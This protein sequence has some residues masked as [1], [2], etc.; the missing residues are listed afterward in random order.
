MSGG[1]KKI[2]KAPDV[3]RNV[4]QANDQFDTATSQAGQL[5]NTAQGYNQSAQDFN[6]RIV[7]QTTPAMD[8][9]NSN[10]TQNLQSYGQNFIPLQQQQ[11]ADAQRMSS[12]AYQAQ[13]RASAMADAG[14]ANAA[15]RKNSQRAL[16]SA[17]VDPYSVQG[18]ALD[19]QAGVVGAATQA[20]AG[21]RA[22]EAAQIQ[23]QQAV[24]NANNLGMQ[25]GQAG[26]ASGATGAQIGQSLVAGT[27]ATNAGAVNNSLAPAT[28]MG[29]AQNANNSA[30]NILSQNYQDQLA[31]TQAQAGGS[32]DMMGN[33]GALGGAAMQMWGGKG[34][35]TSALA[36]GGPVPHE[37]ALPESPIPGSTDTQPAFL[38]P[39]EWV[40]PKD[41]VEW[42]GHEFF[43]KMIDKERVNMNER[44]TVPMQVL[45]HKTDNSSTAR[46]NGGVIP[47]GYSK[48]GAVKDSSSGFG[49][50]SEAFSSSD[51]RSPG[52]RFGLKFDPL[53]Y[54]FGDK[55]REFINMTGDKAN[56]YL[57]KIAKPVN[58]WDKKNNPI[59]KYITDNTAIGKKVDTFA[60]QKPGS[61]IGL[62]AGGYAAGSGIA[63]AGGGSAAG[64]G[65]G[66]LEA[67][68]TGWG[69]AGTANSGLGAF[70]GGSGGGMAS[71]G[72][73]NAGVLASSGGV[74]GGAGI[75]SSTEAGAADAAGWQDWAKMG[76]KAMNQN[77]KQPAAPVQRTGAIPL[78]QV[79]GGFQ[80]PMQVAA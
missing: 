29:V 48:G 57:S 43:H 66:A 35:G 70:G 78:N 55:Y 9:I 76:M 16:T 65:G 60:E 62:I 42:K 45:A 47:D 51:H 68:G 52:T 8:A 23:G 73:G 31:R 25:V 4:N 22:Q 30:A 49:A 12:P 15:A 14:A 74:G 67:G 11:V 63:G 50:A 36:E 64:S 59:H 58:E 28:Y 19:R 39:G 13:Q 71:V 24:A 46:M 5:W 37:G 7:G 33:I 21:Q 26:V 34:G 72:G 79:P 1:S 56:E 3:G 10:A 61:A 17:G 53:A 40:I 44:K 27:N 18:A 77:Q 41:V 20:A 6:T 80:A 54:I 69:G 75:G 2:P 32:Q 38:T